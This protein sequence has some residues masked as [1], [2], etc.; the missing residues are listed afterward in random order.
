MIRFLLY[1]NKP[2]IISQTSQTGTG[3]R[4]EVIYDYFL[5]V[6]HGWHMDPGTVRQFV[7]IV[8]AIEPVRVSHPFAQHVPDFCNPRGHEKCGASHQHH[9][10]ED[11]GGE[12]F[13]SVVL[14]SPSS[15]RWPTQA[16]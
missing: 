6:T 5:S 2:Q 10:P 4:P 16:C 13:T 3:P 9:T 11:L 14:D 7:S 1:Y 15:Y 8:L 12:V